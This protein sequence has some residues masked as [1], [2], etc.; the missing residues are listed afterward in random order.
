MKDY[1]PIDQGAGVGGGLGMIQAQYIYCAFY[2]CNYCIGSSSDHQALDPGGRGPL[3]SA[4]STPKCLVD[5][6]ATESLSAGEVTV[7]L[8]SPVLSYLYIY[9]FP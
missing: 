4:L 5:G 1:F 7:K 2:F 3:P 6:E 9:F 8:C